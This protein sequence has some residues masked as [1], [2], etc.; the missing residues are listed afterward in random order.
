MDGR[1][2]GPPLIAASLEQYAQGFLVTDIQLMEFGLPAADLRDTPQGFLM[3]VYKVV[4]YD[5]I[6]P[7]F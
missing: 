5:D 3:T 2:D 1:L 7:F 4:S 6:L